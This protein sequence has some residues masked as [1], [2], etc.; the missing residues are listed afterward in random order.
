MKSEGVFGLNRNRCRNMMD[1]QFEQ[2]AAEYIDEMPALSPVTATWLGDHL[3][4]GELDEVSVC[5]INP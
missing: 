1:M 3:Y 5:A 2:L 4:D